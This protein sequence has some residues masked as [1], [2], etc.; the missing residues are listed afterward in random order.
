MEAALGLKSI[1]LLPL[2]L[3][4]PRRILLAQEVRRQKSRSPLHDE[5]GWYYLTFTHRGEYL[6]YTDKHGSTYVAISL[7]PRCFV[8]RSSI[9]RWN[10]FLPISEAQ[11]ALI[12][13]R[14]LRLFRAQGNE[15]EV[16]Q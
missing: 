5:Q 11:R 2:R 4:D 9:E 8:S 10:E 14:V 16:V 3:L 1:V 7:V 6:L 15:C 13:E 12:V